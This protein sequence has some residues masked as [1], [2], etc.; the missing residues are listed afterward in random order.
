MVCFISLDYDIAA[1]SAMGRKGLFGAYRQ[2]GSC[3]VLNPI[4]CHAAACYLHKI[5]LTVNRP[6]EMYQLEVNRWAV[7]D[8]WGK[9][10]QQD[11]QYS[12]ESAEGTLCETAEMQVK[13]CKLPLQAG[14]L[15]VP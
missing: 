13:A 15:L 2:V 8:Q 1:S 7:L 11:W 14:N 12:Y 3:H 5:L 10:G 4:I 9:P 6:E